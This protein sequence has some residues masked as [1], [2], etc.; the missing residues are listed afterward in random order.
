MNDSGSFIATIL[1][2][3]TRAFAAGAVSRMTDMKGTANLLDYWPFGQVVSDTELRIRNLAEALAVGRPEV[4]QLDVD[5]LRATYASRGAPVELVGTTLACLRDE[6]LENLPDESQAMVRTY[7]DLAIEKLDEAADAGESLLAEVGP[8]VERA[9]RFLLAALEARHDDARQLVLEAL[10]EGVSVPELHLEVIAR[11][12]AEIGRMWQVGEVNIAE[13]HLGSRIVEDVLSLL[14]SRMPRTAD[15]GRRVVVASVSG[16]LHDIGPR[17]VSDHF[18]MAGWKAL[19][20]GADMPAPDLVQI[21]EDFDAQL[22]ALSGGLGLNLRA[23]AQ[24]IAHVREKRP[25]TPIIV[26]GRPFS[27]VPDLW[28][29]VGADGWAP[30]ASAAVAAGSKLAG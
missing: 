13:E 27:Q 19:F 24:V 12:Q 18:E 8:L 22:V 1:D 4:F 7:L 28:K 3:S 10:D 16:N 15:T 21:L 5:W 30:D 11:A 17:M 23:T 2:T 25:G 26:G 9:R 6:L 20:L 29:D 14:R